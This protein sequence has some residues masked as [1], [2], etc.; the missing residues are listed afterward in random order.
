MMPPKPAPPSAI[1]A[2]IVHWLVPAESRVSATVTPS[3]SSA[4]VS[5]IRRPPKR[6][7][8]RPATVSARAEPHLAEAGRH[9]LL[10]GGVDE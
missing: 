5:A 7:A 1:S 3:S 9:G 10:R 2:A 8:R 4:P 6:S